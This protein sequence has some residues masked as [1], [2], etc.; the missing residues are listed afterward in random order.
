MKLLIVSNDAVLC[1]SRGWEHVSVST[2]KRCPNWQEMSFVKDLFW[3]GDEL[4]I[5]MHPP[6]REYVNNHPNCLHLWRNVT[7]DYPLPPSYFVGL[8]ELG[9]MTNDERARMWIETN[10]GGDAFLLSKISG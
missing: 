9:P 5:Q 8:K 7:V 4:V 6:K 3:D 10:A 1:D 2:P